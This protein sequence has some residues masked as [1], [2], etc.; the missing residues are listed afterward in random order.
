MILKKWDGIIMTSKELAKARRTLD[1]E[2]E[3]TANLIT[4]QLTT[5][6][7]DY[8]KKL[9]EIQEQCTHMWDNGEDAKQPLSK[10]SLCTIC[11]KKFY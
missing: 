6:R 7:E 10:M 2:H 8:N 3:K 9:K 11:R 4:G 5:A 1:D